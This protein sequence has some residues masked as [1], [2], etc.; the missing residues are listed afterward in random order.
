MESWYGCGNDGDLGA[1]AGDRF[2]KK[3]FPIGN[4]NIK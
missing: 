2:L 1:V 4:V 3:V